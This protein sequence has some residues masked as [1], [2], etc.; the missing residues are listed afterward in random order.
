MSLQPP[1][2]AL[3]ETEVQVRED[4]ALHGGGLARIRSAPVAAVRFRFEGHQA[5]VRRLAVHP[6]WQRQGIGSRV[7][8]WAE[9]DLRRRGHRQVR[10]GVRKQLPANLSFY[11]ALG[12]W[13]AEDHGYWLELVKTL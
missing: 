12:Y 9:R 13:V 3:S 1:S 11:E 5:W 4:L 10:L 6:E 8:A 7:M 2:G